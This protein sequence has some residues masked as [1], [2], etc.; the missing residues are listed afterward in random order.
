MIM[1]RLDAEGRCVTGAVA[2]IDSDNREIK[3]GGRNRTRVPLIEVSLTAPTRLLEGEVVRWTDERKVKGVLRLVDATSATVAI[4]SGINAFDAAEL[5]TG[6]EAMFVGLDPWEGMDPWTPDEVPWTH[7]PTTSELAEGDIGDV[8]T[9]TDDD[10]PDLTLAELGEIPI[11]G[12]VG[13]ENEP[14]VVL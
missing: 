9:A 7:R 13:P 14:G 11:V 6:V 12:T 2:S 3:P 8:T 1:A 5:T 10:S 4:T